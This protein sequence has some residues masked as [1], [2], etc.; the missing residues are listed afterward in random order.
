MYL[1]LIYD[2]CNL[3][4]VRYLRSARLVAQF[5]SM[6][7][8][9]L[10]S[11]ASE[12]KNCVWLTSLAW[13]NV[14]FYGNGPCDILYLPFG[15]IGVYRRHKIIWIHLCIYVDYVDIHTWF[16]YYTHVDFS[17]TARRGRFST[18]T[19][20][21]L[22]VLNGCIYGGGKRGQGYVCWYIFDFWCGETIHLFSC[23]WNVCWR[24]V[25]ADT[26]T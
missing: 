5:N 6:L 13:R 23:S 1:W 16:L 22:S 17:R 4:L 9:N 12:N 24:D 3:Q 21:Y 14:F 19:S 8:V 15:N 10:L 20:I 7:Y 2:T 18:V 26:N 25:V 11:L